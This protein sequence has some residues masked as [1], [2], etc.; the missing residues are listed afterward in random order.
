[1]Q[2]KKFE[3]LYAE[4]AEPLLRFLVFRTGDRPLA[5]D[6]LADTFER[7][8]RSGRRFDPRRAS[9]K[10]WLYTIALN[11]LRDKSRRS[12][13]E[14]RALERVGSAA[15]GDDR[16]RGFAHAEAKGDLR[17]ALER[18]PPDQREVVALRFGADMTL[19]E[20]AE[21]TNRARTTVEG[22]FYRALRTLR[23]QMDG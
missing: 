18:L 13:A 8:L 10:T 4:H 16:E 17:R 21:V 2:G 6:L 19:P 11:L 15:G 1:M 7:V 23:E 3:S 12:G 14:T 22:R 5:E 20:I 9:E